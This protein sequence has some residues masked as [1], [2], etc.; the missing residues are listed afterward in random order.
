MVL[1]NHY[2]GL[3]SVSFTP[4]FLRKK[5]IITNPIKIDKKVKKTVS[6]TTVPSGSIA[7]II[8]NGFISFSINKPL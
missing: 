7:N 3:S 2:I 4:L 8:K 6:F 1:L 5:A